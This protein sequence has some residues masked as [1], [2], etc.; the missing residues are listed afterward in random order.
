[1]HAP[2]T[3]DTLRTET[4]MLWYELSMCGHALNAV[5]TRPRTPKTSPP[6]WMV[7]SAHRSFGLT[8]SDL[9]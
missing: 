5:P 1:M 2:F 6:Y 4:A 3:H 7:S 9:R 8:R